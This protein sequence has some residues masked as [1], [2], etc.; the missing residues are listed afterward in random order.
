MRR[1]H[2]T[3]VLVFLF[4]F[5]EAQKKSNVTNAKSMNSLDNN[6]AIYALPMTILNITAEAQ[7]TTVIPGPFYKYADKYLGIQNVPE[8]KITK[9]DISG[10][11]IDIYQEADPEHFYAVS[12]KSIK[13]LKNLLSG[14]AADSLI[15]YPDRFFTKHSYTGTDT[16]DNYRIHY[17]DLSV[18]RNFHM[19]D[20]TTYK[21]ILRDSVYV[22]IPVI[23]QQ[24]VRKSIEEKA[25]EAADY[26]I[27]IRKR[28]FKLLSGQYDYM[29]EGEAL[30]VAVKEMEK[31]EDEY[32]SLFTGKKYIDSFYKTF[33]YLPDNTRKMS[34]EVLC[35]FSAAE[36]FIDSREARGK[37][38]II[39][40]KDMD[41]TI[42][43]E[44]TDTPDTGILEGNYV[45]VRLPDLAE[46]R[47]LKGDEILNETRVPVFQYGSIVP[48]SS[49][50]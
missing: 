18:K 23:K 32:L 8:S 33:Q 21:S 29:P 20:D 6:A 17:R 31:L 5:C 46:I 16:T 38:V 15:L 39:E 4:A 10:I 34:K 45:P 12:N 42:Y 24:L 2:I 44:K 25:E 50:K 26:I 3:V 43:F 27:K 37:P 14:L 48:F 49:R 41:K 40:I 30:E 22:K 36:G 47:I 9:W 28:K 13:N 11:R 35:R 19:S 1:I 7:R